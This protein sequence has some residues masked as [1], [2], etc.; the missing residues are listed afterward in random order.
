M[1]LA[2]CAA[3]APPPA[4]AA[5]QWL[6]DLPRTSPI[7]HGLL[8]LCAVTVAGLALGA[9]RFRGIGLGVAGV[10]FSGLLFGHLG[11]TID[12]Q[13][14][15]FLQEFGLILFVYTIGLQVGPGFLDSLRRDGLPLNLAAAAVVGLGAALT[16]ALARAFDVDMAAAVGVFSGATTNTP[17]LGA[18]QEALRNLTTITPER[19]ALPGLG[20]AVAYPFGIVGIILTMLIVRLTLRINLPAEVAAFATA[21]AATLPVLERR[22]LLV[23]NPNLEG[24]AVRQLPVLGAGG[25]VISRVRRRGETEV[26]PA[27]PDTLLHVGD[28]LLAVG[29]R[30]KLDELQIVVGRRTDEDL[31]AAPGTVRQRRI[32]LTRRP[33]VGRTLRELSLDV[34]HGATVTRL[35]RADIE[36]P[37][38]PDV[39]LQFGDM[40]MIV[41]TDE[42]LARAR[43]ALGDSVQ[44]LNHTSLIPMFIG[45]ALGVL[46]G[47]FPLQL[48]G[49][50]APLRLGLAGGPLLIAI[51]LSRVGRIGPLLWHMPVNANFLLR[52][53]GIVLFLGCVGLKAGGHFVA[54][55]R[56]GDGWLWMACGAVITLVP[57]LLVGFVMR[58]V[59]RTNF[60]S[61]CGLLAGSMTDPPA[62]AF[63]HNFT[64]SDAPAVAYA[65]VYPV[66][67]LLRIILAQ[68][69]VLFFAG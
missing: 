14:R 57:L 30:S 62:L 5:M 3:I 18:A 47:M 15:E 17:S 59:Q 22:T 27:H 66:T 46:A 45:I 52:E 40:L 61:L 8:V 26:I 54:T 37:A 68:V 44:Q 60:L 36:L 39:R 51:I 65:T 7:A 29:E 38:S 16:L 19:A 31:T 48:S 12:P 1:V 49:M 2:D 69:L 63:A 43:D 4:W 34:L 41:G 24:M 11:L 53:I 64:N 20:Y 58:L 32:V 9:A 56:A 10:L 67:M 25:A 42:A 28:A 50:P 13:V 21:R 23:D 35:T 33:M 55:L 6:L